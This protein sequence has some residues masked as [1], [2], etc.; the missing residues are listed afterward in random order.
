MRPL[1]WSHA[2]CLRVSSGVELE[3]DKTSLCNKERKVQ[4]SCVSRS[5][6]QRYETRYQRSESEYSRVTDFGYFGLSNNASHWTVSLLSEARNG[7]SHRKLTLPRWFLHR[8]GAILKFFNF[9][10]RRCFHTKASW[11]QKA[12]C[13]STN[14]QLLSSIELFRLFGTGGIKS[15]PKF[16]LLRFSC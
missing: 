8:V 2:E 4:L 13:Y 10:T 15:D 11:K 1:S 14:K 5:T 7:I 12:V 9:H 6:I 16:S 3:Y